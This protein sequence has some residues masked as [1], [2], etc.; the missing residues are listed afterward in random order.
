MVRRF[1]SSSEDSF[2][3]RYDWV[4]RFVAVLF[5]A[6]RLPQNNALSVLDLKKN[7]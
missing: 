3:Y 4:L 5:A 7:A 2:V 6:A 1:R